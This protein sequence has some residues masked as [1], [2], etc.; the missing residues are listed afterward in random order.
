MAG[1]PLL[2]GTGRM[3]A[4]EPVFNI[5][6]DSPLSEHA[7]AIQQ[8]L[9]PDMH[10][11]GIL[12]PN[13]MKRQLTIKEIVA[14]NEKRLQAI[15]YNNIHLATGES[16]EQLAQRVLADRK[17]ITKSSSRS[18]YSQRTKTRMADRFKK[19]LVEQKREKEKERV[20][21]A[22]NEKKEKQILENLK[23]T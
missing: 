21:K 7:M 17:S 4:G 20:K 15:E 12:S 19:S 22:N 1:N 13:S 8:D 6:L 3:G 5:N 16:I 11:I 2:G 14:Y 9:A 10:Y 23:R 18:Q